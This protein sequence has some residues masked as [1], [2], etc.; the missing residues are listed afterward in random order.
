M[1]RGIHRLTQ[2]QV[3][4]ARK[5]WLCDG[6]GLYLQASRSWV[7]RYKRGGRTRMM[8]LGSCHTVS[9]PRARELARAAREQLHAGI[10]PLAARA[11]ARAVTRT[12]TF[13]QCADA[14]IAAHA[15]GW[16]N[17][18]HAAQW[19]STLAT[20]AGPVLGK[21]PIAAIDTA[22][23]MQVL[24]ELWTVK[25]DTASRL[26]GRMEQVLGWATINGY[27]SGDNPARWRGHLQHLLPAKSK[28]RTVQ[29]YAA[30]PYAELPAFMAALRQQDGIAARALEFLVLTAVRTGDIVGGGRDDAPCLR[31]GDVDLGNKVWTI[32]KTKTG[33]AHRVPLSDAALAVLAQMRPLADDSGIVFG[34]RRR[35]QPLSNGTFLGLLNRMGADVTAHGF[36][37]TFKTWASERTGYAREVVE[38]A[39]SHTIPDELER[40]YRRGDLFEKRTTLMA[41]WA[42]YCTAPPAT[43]VPLRA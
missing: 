41:D 12:M 1:A 35:G 27:R 7:F 29:H 42:A 24:R 33:T 10:D 22:L 15:A 4:R 14:Y 26:R 36:R 30:L 34:G 43:V 28:L 5:R 8:G 11:T 2:L 6:G 37:A 3:Q 18:K 25:P 9:L 23:I 39:L 31:W 17:P 19:A 38:A 13:Q 20:Y 32:P 16:R 21:L 40:A